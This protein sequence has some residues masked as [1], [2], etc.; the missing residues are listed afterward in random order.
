MTLRKIKY[1]EIHLTK[2]VKHLY[3]ENWK[4]LM[5][6]IEDDTNRWKDILRSWIG[7]MNIVKMTILTKASYRFKAIPIK[8]PMAF[9]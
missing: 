4:T 1:L 3:S 6:E 2:E 5:K 7:R 9:S 8:I